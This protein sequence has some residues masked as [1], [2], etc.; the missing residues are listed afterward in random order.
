MTVARGTVGASLT[1]LEGEE[2]VRGQAL[3]A[4]EHPLERP[5]HVAIVQSTIAR[6]RV[7]AVDSA[8]ALD[9]GALAVLSH[10]NA[11]R[12]ALDVEGELAVL[13][14]SDVAYRGQ[15]VAAAIAE[16][17]EAAREAA[18]LVSVRYEE[19]PH[20]SLLTADHP[21]LYR[22]EKVNPDFE[23]DTEQGDHAAAFASAPARVDVVYET[24]SFHNNPM[25]PHASSAVWHDGSLTVYDSTQ[26]AEAARETIAATFGLDPASVHVVS[27]HVGGGFGS[28]GT[29]RPHTILAV[30]AAR[31]AARPAKLPVT[32]QQ[33]FALTGYRTPTIQRIRL[34]AE[35]DG[36][37][38]AVGHDVVEQSSTLEEFAE[39]TAV[40]TRMMYAAPNRRTSH[41]LARLNVPTPSWMRAPGETPGMYALESAMDELAI[42]CGLDPVELRIR[43]EPDT[44]PETG[45]AFSSR[46]LVA[47]LR[48]GAERFGWW[49]R[50]ARPA[51]RRDGQ[52]LSGTGV[53]AST[54]PARRRPSHARARAEVDG[55]FVVSLAASDV[56]TGARTVLTQIAAEELSVPAA[57]VRLELGDSD[58]P[59]APLAG[60]SMGTASWG[61]AITKVCRELASRLDDDPALPL[62]VEADTE[63]EIESDADF[64]RHAF[65]AQFAEVRVDAGTGEVRVSRLLGVFAAGRILNPKTARSQFLGGMTMGISMALHEESRLD[66]AFGDYVNHDLAGYHVAACA[67]VEELEAH[68]IDEVD[69]HLNPM[70]SKGIG[71]IG[72]VG[73]AAAIGNAVHHATG[74]RVRTVPIRPDRIVAALPG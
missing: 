74:L 39:Q 28:K 44:D 18:R 54:Y 48:E 15:I 2:K 40:P 12:L 13:Q 61:S 3:Y 70:G 65:G 9:A 53:A 21:S 60:G 31:I 32:R 16:T 62:E 51:V 66:P 69:D 7:A 58:L 19:E 26:G 20:D 46:G 57:T 24:S 33:M 27:P 63:S 64:A 49:E 35:L 68:W 5:V 17:P 73:T 56:G 71:E 45:F 42:A 6:G 52:W 72:I 34:G 55:S 50:D 36:T 23:T 41:R 1:R 4:D 38:V 30:M 47:C 14:S 67:D 25:E 43:N 37:L 8:A 11:P 22:P 29:V 10:E 59:A